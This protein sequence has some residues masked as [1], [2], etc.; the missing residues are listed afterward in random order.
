MKLIE[1]LRLRSD[2]ESL[3]VSWTEGR[4]VLIV[5]KMRIKAEENL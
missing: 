1:D 3:Y 4:K 2:I 5:Y